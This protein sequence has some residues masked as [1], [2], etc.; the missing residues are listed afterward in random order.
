MGPDRTGIKPPTQSTSCGQVHQSANVTLRRSIYHLKV[1]KVETCQRP[2]PTRK[3][4]RV[5]TL[6]LSQ[7]AEYALRATLFLAEVEEDRPHRVDEIA[8]SLRVPRNYLSKTLHTLTRA[9]VLTSL[10]GP[11][12]GFQLAI[13]AEELHLREV[14]RHFNH[15]VVERRCLLGM[16]RCGEGEGCAAH[17]RWES[18]AL[19]VEAFFEETTIAQL[20]TDRKGDG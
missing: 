8:T 18:V 9:G 13:P 10:R 11:R 4:G 16:E 2:E 14:I 7:T 17:A 3:P 5:K 12:G 1:M 15:F 19:M 6:I 20:S